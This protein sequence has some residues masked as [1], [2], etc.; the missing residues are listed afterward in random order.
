MRYILPKI[1][2]MINCN[3]LQ[4]VF[5]ILSYYLCLSNLYTKWMYLK[6]HKLL[7]FY[8]TFFLDEKSNKKI[9]AI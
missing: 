5:M 9:K 1:G 7:F 8:F 4:K 3:E 2:E 6:C